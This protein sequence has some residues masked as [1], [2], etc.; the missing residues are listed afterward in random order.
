MNLSAEA[1]LDEKKF[2]DAREDNVYTAD[3]QGLQPA[4]RYFYKVTGGPSEYTGI[5]S[6]Q[7]TTA[8]V[9][10]DGITPVRLFAESDLIG[11]LGPNVSE[12]IADFHKIHD[13]V[14]EIWI[15]QGD[16]DQGNG[17]MSEYNDGSWWDPFRSMIQK[18]TIYTAIGNHDWICSEDRDNGA[19]GT[20]YFSAFYLP[21]GSFDSTEFYYSYDYG[22]VRFICTFGLPLDTNDV[23]HK[24]IVEQLS[25]TTPMWKI[26]YNHF[27]VYNDVG[28]G[29]ATDRGTLGLSNNG[30]K[31]YDSLCDKYG[32]DAMIAGHKGG[33]HQSRPITVN[34]TW[35]K[36]ETPQGAHYTKTRRGPETI[37]IQA[38]SW[39]RNQ[40]FHLEFNGNVMTGTNWK[41]NTSADSFY[42]NNLFTLTKTVDGNEPP[43]AVIKQPHNKWNGVAGEQMTLRGTAGDL[44]DGELGDGVFEWSYKV[45]RPV[46]NIVKE[47]T[48]I[49]GNSKSVQF[50][51]TIIGTYTIYLTVTDKGGAKNSDKITV[52]ITPRLELAAGVDFGDLTRWAQ[53]S[54]TQH[55][56]KY[57][58]LPSGWT[59]ESTSARW[60]GKIYIRDRGDQDVMPYDISASRYVITDSI[61]AWNYPLENGD[62][63][64]SLRSAIPDPIYSEDSPRIKSIKLEGEE[65]VQNQVICSGLRKYPT[66]NTGG[67]PSGPYV[68]RGKVVEVNYWPVRVADGNLT[69]EL[70]SAFISS[71]SIYKADNTTVKAG[72]KSQSRDLSLSISP[73]PFSETLNIDVRAPVLP[74]KGDL[75]VEIYDIRGRLIER[76]K[77]VDNMTCFNWNSANRSSGIYVVLVQA[78]NMV[79]SNKISLMK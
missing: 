24:W 55:L 12:K 21:M 44:E 50:T 73:N 71:L 34:D 9:K 53:K 72:L 49:A 40:K 36:V 5:D 67:A 68:S 39:N 52:H 77:A 64:V 51:P 19:Y 4:A 2:W 26:M 43:V 30:I 45:E 65:V 27:P 37:F 7:F 56:L 1:K 46:G 15:C 41:K 38:E 20:Y 28:W 69:L 79:M 66:T 29:G 58:A 48:V 42:I 70:D 16:V 6:M 23:Q 35:E 17:C 8:P 11:D 18:T 47:R 32:V 31:H 33:N 25:D 62:Y 3:L 74:A 61:A 57:L 76:L 75:K 54:S 13:P 14:P 22:N 63:Y 10:G 60:T 78:G 59:R